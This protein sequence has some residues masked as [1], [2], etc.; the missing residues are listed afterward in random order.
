[1]LMVG[2]GRELDI[3]GDGVLELGHDRGEYSEA[4]LVVLKKT[5]GQAQP[6][7]M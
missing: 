5:Y 6:Q 7:R 1:M 4:M 3:D 2:E